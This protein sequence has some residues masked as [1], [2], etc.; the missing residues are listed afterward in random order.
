MVNPLCIHNNIVGINNKTKSDIPTYLHPFPC[1]CTF[2]GYH[3]KFPD[4][5]TEMHIFQ[6]NN[7]NNNNKQWQCHSIGT[8]TGESCGC[9][10]IRHSHAMEGT[11]DLILCKWGAQSTILQDNNNRIFHMFLLATILLGQRR[12]RKSKPL[13]HIMLE[14]CHLVHAVLT[15]CALQ[16]LLEQTVTIV[17][18]F[19]WRD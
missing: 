16:S 4:F 11:M 15:S 5:W 17:E 19:V 8:I 9:T 10:A 18:L 1:E 3:S 7:N 2:Y 6:N 12:T 13:Q 14:S